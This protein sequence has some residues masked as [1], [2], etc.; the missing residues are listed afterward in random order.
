MCCVRG[1][2]RALCGHGKGLSFTFFIPKLPSAKIQNIKENDYEGT[3]R[4]AAAA[5]AE[6]GLA[7]SASDDEL[8]QA[9]MRKKK[10]LG[11]PQPP[12]HL[13]SRFA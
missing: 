10:V 9:Q 13:P 12:T 11:D 8:A 7:P 2:Q 3:Q 1:A 5:R 6:V 4:K